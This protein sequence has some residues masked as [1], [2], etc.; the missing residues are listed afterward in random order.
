M[1]VVNGGREVR[2]RCELFPAGRGMARE[3]EESLS[4]RVLGV[5]AVQ[6]ANVISNTLAGGGISAILIRHRHPPGR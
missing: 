1:A 3:G 5:R 6:M 2:R 4:V